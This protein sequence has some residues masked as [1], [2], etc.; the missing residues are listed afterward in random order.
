MHR[1]YLDIFIHLWM[2]LIRFD[3]LQQLI[4]AFFAASLLICYALHA[5]STRWFDVAHLSAPT[6][7]HHKI[8]LRARHSSIGEHGN[9]SI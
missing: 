4:Y 2:N 7:P 3:H 5:H 6:Y 9:D 8:V 1:Q